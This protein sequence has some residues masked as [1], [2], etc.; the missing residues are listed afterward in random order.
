M[1][2]IPRSMQQTAGSVNCEHP[3]LKLKWGSITTPPWTTN[4]L[5][6]SSFVRSLV[7]SFVEKLRSFV[8]LLVRSFVLSFVR[9]F[10]CLLMRSSSGNP[11]DNAAA[12]RWSVFFPY[13]STLSA[14]KVR[15]VGSLVRLAGQPYRP[16]A[17]IWS[18]ESTLHSTWIRTWIQL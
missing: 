6:V 9:S 16:L 4:L 15:G 8:R 7:R 18:V 3:L 17:Q 14:T 11:N 5:F 12:Q 2:T 10:V 13:W 1:R